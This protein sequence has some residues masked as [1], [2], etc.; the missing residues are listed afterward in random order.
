MRDDWYR[1]AVVYGIDIARFCDSDGSGIGDIQGVVNKLGYIESLGVTCLW[2]LPFFPSARRDNGYDITQYKAV[3][4][5]LGSLTDLRELIAKSHQKGIKII[6]DLVVHHTSNE[7][8]WFIA[9]ENSRKS[10]LHDYYVWSDHPP[11]NPEDKPSFTGQEDSTWHYSEQAGAYYHHKFYHFEPDLN[12]ANPAVWEEIKEVADFW[13]TFDIDGFRLDAA[14]DM[15]TQKGLPGT[16]VDTQQALKDLRDF[17]DERKPG[18][19][20]LAEAD[21][22]MGQLSN[23]SGQDGKENMLYNF[24]LNNSM[25]LAMARQQAAPIVGRLNQLHDL[26]ATGSWLNFVRNLD[27]LDLE[28]LSDDELGE[29]F[30]AFAPEP[31]MHIFGKGIRRAVAPMLHDMHRLKMFYS[32]LFTM[33]G[34]PLIMNGA[35]IGKGDDLSQPGRSS[36]RI[37]MQWSAEENAGFSPAKDPGQGVLGA[38]VRQGDFSYTKVNVASQEDDPAS[39]LNFMRSLIAVRGRY[40]IIGCQA[41]NIVD[42]GNTAVLA[43]EF[44]GIM[45][46]HNLSGAEQVCHI[47]MPDG[48]AC[49]FGQDYTA[50]HKLE[51]YGYSW[52]NLPG[53][54]S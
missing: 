46:L 50:A 37:P 48:A 23:F 42:P 14:T 17:I 52:I 15:F 53:V 5:E 7:H 16:A 43:L 38:V 1:N 39:L 18:A 45:T 27:E 12:I 20:I 29:V 34:A 6:L 40:P 10:K 28:H 30:Q 51:P 19:L 8:P 24:L 32:L 21:V 4:P 44:D 9:A 25:Y 36:V 35:E 41:A 2:L 26:T 22:D 31:D 47:G 11:D 33:P 13:L 3:D 54:A 49:V